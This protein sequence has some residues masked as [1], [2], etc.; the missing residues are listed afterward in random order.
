MT[1]SASEGL[2]TIPLK[3]GDSVCVFVCLWFIEE[4]GFAAKKPI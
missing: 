3:V 2:S 4:R 1:I